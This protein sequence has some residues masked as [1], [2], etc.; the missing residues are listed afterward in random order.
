MDTNS[1]VSFPSGKKKWEREGK[2]KGKSE[3]GKGKGER[4]KRGGKRR[5]A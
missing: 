2:G 4:E 3:E 5:E 1:A